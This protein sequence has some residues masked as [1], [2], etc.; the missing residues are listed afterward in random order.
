[1][2]K[3]GS[4]FAIICAYITSFVLLAGMFPRTVFADSYTSATMRLL[5]YEGTVEIEDSAGKPRAVMENARLNSGEAMKTAEASSASVGLDE[6]R[7]V[8]MDEKSR[9]EFE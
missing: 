4:L 8:T 3:K 1:M 2:K 6:G 5:R 9:V 7:I